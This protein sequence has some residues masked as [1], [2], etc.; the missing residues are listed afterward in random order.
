LLTRPWID[1]AVTAQL[2]LAY[3]CAALLFQ[4]AV[5]ICVALWRRQ[6][7]APIPSPHTASRE[8]SGAWPG[9][10]EFRVVRREFEDSAHTQCSFYLEP[11]D[12]VPLPPFV[13]GQFLTFALTIVDAKG[14]K[15][16]LTRCYSLSDR[17]EPARY[18][19]TVKRV[20][21]PVERPQ[22]APGACSNH[23][24]DAV[25]MGDLVKVKAPAGRFVVDSDTTLPVVL[26]A[27]GVGITPLMSMLQA[28]LAAEPHR[29]VHLYYG[30]RHG[31]EHAFRAALDELA[32]LHSNFHLN[33][34]YSRPRP[35]DARDRAFHH[36]G[37]VDV[38]LLRRTLPI[39]RHGFY[40]CGPP[41]MMASLIPG[42][43]EWGVLPGDVHYEQFGPAS[44]RSTLSLSK[45]SVPSG[46]P[47]VE[48]KFRKSGRTLVWDGSDASLLDFAER[49]DVSIESG[50]RAGSCGSCETKILAGTVSYAH[51]PDHQPARGYC[52]LCVG[53]PERA[54]ELEA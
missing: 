6:H 45:D 48:V 33:V 32:R 49:H 46:P 37:H 17:P 31:G 43:E 21:A 4:L 5:G 24:H 42:L 26:I 15:R 47:S 50:C 18:R 1:D 12:G 34:V 25:R 39:G 36:A 13:P 51:E 54:L 53:T 20:T 19:I 40:L 16:T 3:I 30:V 29:Q 41:P 2:L 10:R 8:S 44:V 28:G 23:F 9:W 11:A 14:A 27:G 52:L 38:D 22:L 7:F 35:E